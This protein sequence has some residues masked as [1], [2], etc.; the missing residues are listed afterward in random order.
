MTTLK[1]AVEEFLLAGQA[2]GKS[3]FTTA[4]YEAELRGFKWFA[5]REGW[6]E[7]VAGITATHIRQFLVYLRNTP[8]RFGSTNGRARQPVNNTTIR[9][10]FHVLSSLFGWLVREGIL[11]ESPTDRVKVPRSRRKVIKALTAAQV[12]QL[13][14]ACDKGYVGVR[15]KAMISVLVDCGLRLGELI[16][17]RMNDVDLDAQTLKMAGKTGERKA[18]FGS[19]TTNA[20]KAYIQVRGVVGDEARLWTIKRGSPLTANSFQV[21][22]RKLSD[23]VGFHVHVHLLR[24]SFATLYLRNGGDALMLQR[25]LGHTTL[26]MTERYVQAIGMEDAMASHSRFGP[27]DHLA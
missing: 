25:L 20:L 10:Y 21:S 17:L 8:R 6:S 5:D 9:N 4:S 22:I 26:G 1:H 27:M 14:A 24:H 11:D 23:K 2:E 18:R 15:N 3:P 16:G 7:D 19:A 12:G 13:L